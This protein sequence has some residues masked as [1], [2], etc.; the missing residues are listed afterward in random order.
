MLRGEHEPN[1]LS[2]P[3]PSPLDEFL[4]VGERE[5][6]KD[7]VLDIILPSHC[8]PAFF[9]CIQCPTERHPRLEPS[10]FRRGGPSSHRPSTR[11]R[12]IRMSFNMA[13]HRNYGRTSE[14]TSEQSETLVLQFSSSSSS[15]SCSSSSRSFH[16]G[17]DDT[18]NAGMEEIGRRKGEKERGGRGEGAS[19]WNVRWSRA[20]PF[21]KQVAT[22]AVYEIESSV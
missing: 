9:I 21:S 2:S 14:R 15:S 13:A 4:S 19:W 8:R 12:I 17:H 11:R 3:L 16:I 20:A 18:W 7:G 10:P 5:E 1:A 6:K 22:V